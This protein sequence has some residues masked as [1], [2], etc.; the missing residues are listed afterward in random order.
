MS[1]GDYYRQQAVAPKFVKDCRKFL[2]GVLLCESMYL[3]SSIPVPDF[4]LMLNVVACGDWLVFNLQQSLDD[5]GALKIQQK[6]VETYF[7]I[8]EC[9]NY[10][11]F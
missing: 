5:R 6:L 9:E 3:L 7:N 4:V 11:N 1:L 2:D 8:G 10:C